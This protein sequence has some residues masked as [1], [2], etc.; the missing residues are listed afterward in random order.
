[1]SAATILLVDD[2]EVLSQVLRRVLTRDGYRVVEAGSVAQALEL[3]RED[4]PQ[5]GL[6]DLS[7]PDGDG[8]ELATKLR[9]QGVDCPL[10][11]V[12][13]YPLRLRDQ[14][15]LSG[16]FTR[17]LT[18]PLNLQDLRQAIEA[19]LIPV[20]A[21]VG[22]EAQ[23]ASA[24]APQVAVDPPRDSDL[25]Q[26]LSSGAASGRS[27]YVV[28]AALVALACVL[29][30]MVLPAI[31][32]PGPLDWFNKAAT[33]VASA[34][35]D[36]QAPASP[37]KGDPDGVQLSQEVK[38]RLA[39]QVAQV[40]PPK[41]GRQLTLSGSLNFDPDLLAQVHP[42]FSGEVIEI[43]PYVPRGATHP[44]DRALSFGDPVS[45]GQLLAVIWSKDLGE[46]KNDLIE[47]LA[48]VWTDQT[49]LTALEELASEGAGSGANV[50]LQKGV[51]AADYSAVDRARNALHIWRLTDKEIQEVEDNAKAI[52]NERTKA[53]NTKGEK[54][55]PPG[56]DWKQ[57]ARTE[58][59]ANF[60]GTIVER[61][62]EKTG[63]LVDV[64][65][66]LFK[67]ADLNKLI[68]L[69]YAYEE[70]LPDLL[71]LPRPIPWEVRAATD[72]PEG[73]L[74]TGGVDLIGPIIDPNQHTALVMGHVDNPGPAHP[75]RAGQFIT[76]TISLPAPDN[77]VAVP[78]TAVV[79]TGAESVVFVQPDRTKPI[80][81]MRR[82]AVT[83]RYP[84]EIKVLSKLLGNEGPRYQALHPG[85]W[86]VTEGAMLLKATLD[87]VQAKEESKKPVEK[88]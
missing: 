28:V 76:A 69:T 86:V 62:V 5:L 78:A 84:T 56:G 66:T 49:T 73:V 20:A 44:S 31:G 2:D 60:S 21:A 30:L 57:W 38:E 42:R 59:Q 29:A 67:I 83:R 51:V 19:A 71:R 9:A 6:L 77:V 55:T 58:V 82:V 68:A 34:A 8:M 14:P 80:Y 87:D 52:Y 41:Q 48:K 61:N 47:G 40:E 81:S 18:K 26:S 13:A 63:A 17:I 15:E 24:E 27:R 23:T 12:T 3:T 22:A 11:L 1:M 72:A 16:A 7:L 10:I 75:L 79:E 35:E 85:E 32:L 39:I 45:K 4:K 37:V 36:N 46:K 53:L 25:P 64:T 54:K 33:P 74:T 70:D 43:G 88:K 65:A 50:R